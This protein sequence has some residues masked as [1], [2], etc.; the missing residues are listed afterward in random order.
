VRLWIGA[1]AAAVFL[2]GCGTAVAA[3]VTGQLTRAVTSSAA[4]AS[5][6]SGPARA[7]ALARH[8]IAE[9]AFPRGTR[10]AS[11]RSIP[12]ALRDP[13]PPGAH[14]A[15]AQR[16]LLAPVKPAAVWAVLMDHAPFGYGGTVGVGSSGPVGS[17]ALLPAPEPGIAAAEAVVWMEPWK[18]GTT[19]IAAYAYAT[20]LPVRTAAEHL[21]PGSLRAVTITADENIPRRSTTT[22]TYT[23]ARIIERLAAYLNARQAAPPIAVPC[24]FPATSYQLKFIPR[25]RRGPVV[26]VAPSCMTDSIT[27]NGAAQPSLWDLHGGLVS[28]IRGLPGL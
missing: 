17:V 16:L 21:S 13:G 11:L 20:W 8:L 23:S 14:W 25:A 26:T 24:P 4:S 7:Q 9:M 19:L 27:V 15:K 12:A 2:A 6:A 1:A 22:R 18:N 28:I 10:Q 5:A 3:P